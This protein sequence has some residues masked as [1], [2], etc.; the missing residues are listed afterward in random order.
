MRAVSIDLGRRLIASGLVSPDEVEAALFVSVV[1]GVPFARVLL[2]RGAVTE[3]GL[4]EEL[5]RVGGL[6][7]R[8]VAGALEIYHRLPRALC[9]RLAALPTRADPETG[10]IEVAAADPLDPHV[11]A[12][13]GFHLGAPIRVIRAPIAAVE[14][15]IRRLE[16]DEP[17]PAERVRPR[18]MTPASPYGAPQST[19]P[20]P[21]LEEAPIPLVRK[22]PGAPPTPP[23]SA[24]LVPPAGAPPLAGFAVP[25][26]KLSSIPP[27]VTAPYPVI[28]RLPPTEEA[29]AY[30]ALH[31]QPDPPPQ[32]DEEPKSVS[33]PEGDRHTPTYGTPAFNSAPPDPGYRIAPPAEDPLPKVR[34]AQEAP[35]PQSPT[36]ARTVPATKPTL[37]SASFA[38][39]APP[40]QPAPPPRAQART[41]PVLG[42]I[43]Y[44]AAIPSQMVPPDGRRSA[45]PGEEVED[46][47]P[48]PV[49][50]KR[51]R[52]PDAG[53]V[54]TALANA[55]TRD[56]VIRV[57]MRGTRLVARRIAVF[58]VKRDGF[59]GWACNVEMGDEDALRAIHVP[60]DLPS[61]LATATATAIYLGPIPPTPAH[62]SLLR[63]MERASPDVAAVTVR[64]AGRAALVLL[65]DDLDDTMIG[66]RFLVELARAVGD[67]LA[68]LIAR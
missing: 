16:L 43:P 1:R 17:E 19:I 58:A 25:A 59:H 23:R 60:A 35:P 34:A 30:A 56:D 46:E 48:A 32:P 33:F 21:V 11:A 61:V 51:A 66:T 65:A 57:A 8:Q 36:P 29:H 53:P 6:G 63:V 14:E 40:P 7:M 64:V 50:P 38:D 3:R 27:P 54:M 13:I 39:R 31:A 37:L 24:T 12:E 68:R 10:A 67:A 49:A 18:R 20:P 22:A 9:R 28:D 2:D 5:E 62:E 26:P 44:P 55:G 45:L 41:R 42:D 15:A 52:A 47:A 4:E